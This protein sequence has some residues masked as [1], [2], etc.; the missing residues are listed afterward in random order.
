VTKDQ[1]S[2]KQLSNE[3]YRNRGYFLKD[4]TID[5]VVARGFMWTISAFE[6]LNQ[7]LLKLVI[8]SQ[9]RTS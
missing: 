7:S 3:F 6:W 9:R 8:P 5:K 1:G 2:I 4:A